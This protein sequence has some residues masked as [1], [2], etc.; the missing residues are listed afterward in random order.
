M[1]SSRP[2]APAPRRIRLPP[3]WPSRKARSRASRTTKASGP[4]TATRPPPPQGR[5]PRRRRL[6]SRMEEPLS[7]EMFFRSPTAPQMP[8]QP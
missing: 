7:M 6:V 1:L 4:P 2:R 5:R 3:S 8:M